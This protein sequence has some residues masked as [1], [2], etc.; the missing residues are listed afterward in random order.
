NP[1]AVNPLAVVNGD[2]SVW[3]PGDASFPGWYDHEGGGTGGIVI[4]ASQNQYLQLASGGLSPELSLTHCDLYVPPSADYL[5]FDFYR[6]YNST[7]DSGDILQVSLG[8]I[9]LSIPLNQVDSGWQTAE[10]TNLGLVADQME[11]LTFQIV[12]DPLQSAGH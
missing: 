6:M 9:T 5:K 7:S 2:F 1:N 4:D 10:L 11:K 12:L 8:G 3:S